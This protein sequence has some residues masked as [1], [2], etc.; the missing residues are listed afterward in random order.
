MKKILFLIALV[1]PL[2]L[3]AQEIRDIDIR[4]VVAKD[5]SAT[6]TTDWD[7]TV[8]SGT[9]WYIPIENLGPMKV[10]SLKVSEGG[11]TFV[12]EGFNWDSG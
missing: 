6:V 7:V 12:D 1:F 2:T 3:G 9:E 5:G 10:T 11:K 8:T 4:V